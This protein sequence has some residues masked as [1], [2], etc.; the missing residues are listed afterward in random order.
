MKSEGDHLVPDHVL[1]ALRYSDDPQGPFCQIYRAC[2]LWVK[3]RGSL[4][5]D[6]YLDIV[7]DS[8]VQELDALRLPD[9]DA[10]EVSKR[11]VRALDRNRKRAIRARRHE[12]ELKDFNS[13]LV[14]FNGVEAKIEAKHMFEVARVLKG[15]ISLSLDSLSDRDYTL[16]YTRYDLETYGIKPRPQNVSLESLKPGARKTALSRARVRLLNELERR[17]SEAGSCLDEDRLAVRDALQLVRSGVVLRN[18]RK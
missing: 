15:F 18:G 11:L 16:I 17:L 13:A 12:V 1:E 7:S 9:L 5:T 6:V 10:A 4:P 8:I 2:F 14:A 3:K